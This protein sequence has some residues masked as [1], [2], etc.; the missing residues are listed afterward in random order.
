MPFH[1][2]ENLVE[3]KRIRYCNTTHHTTCKTRK[4][5]KE[6]KTE[7]VLLSLESPIQG[8]PDRL[9]NSF[10][11]SSRSSWAPPKILEFSCTRLLW[12]G[13]IRT[14]KEKSKAK[15]KENEKEK[16]I[17]QKRKEKE[18]EKEKEKK[19]KRKEKEKRKEKKRK[20]KNTIPDKIWHHVVHGSIW[21][22]LVYVDSFAGQ[23]QSQM[24]WYTHQLRKID[25]GVVPVS[26][27]VLHGL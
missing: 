11:I 1:L 13:Y 5:I 8:S 4:A 25:V 6:K 18:K 16:W 14:K 3:R 20:A 7:R 2:T 10:A 9:F 17:K 26:G 24:I 23:S 22:E 15:E 19:K 27:I 12:W 21:Q